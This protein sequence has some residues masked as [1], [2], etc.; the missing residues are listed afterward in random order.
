MPRRLLL[1][2]I[3]LVA[4]PLA[5]LGWVSAAA[6]RQQQSAAAA[7]LHD[8]L[9]RRLEEI[10]RNV[11]AVFEEYERELTKTM[12]GSS[13]AIATLR[14][15]QLS[16]PVVRQG[17]F[18]GKDGMLLYPPK[19]TADDPEMIS[20]HAALSA[21]IGGRP[22]LANQDDSAPADKPTASGKKIAPKRAVIE[23]SRWQVWYMDEGAQLIL[24][25]V[26]QYHDPHKLQLNVEYPK[27]TPGP[28]LTCN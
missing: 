20:L 1:A 25:F 13:Q 10:D 5:L 17:I 11:S 15:L 6:M 23:E 18:V 24:W 7:R 4:A 2:L 21:M 26:P 22:D 8:L 12:R 14:R 27:H 3:V 19:P 28:A 9:Q 16:E